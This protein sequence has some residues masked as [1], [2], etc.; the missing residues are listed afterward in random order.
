MLAEIGLLRQQQVE[1]LETQPSCVMTDA[2]GVIHEAN[3]PGLLLL[4]AS[5]RDLGTHSIDRFVHGAERVL[6][7]LARGDAQLTAPVSLRAITPARRLTV[8]VRRAG[9]SATL[10]H[11]LFGQGIETSGPAPASKE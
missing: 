10:W 4:G 11:W 8:R 2:A 9:R 6:A 7:G 1:F 5:V 3:T